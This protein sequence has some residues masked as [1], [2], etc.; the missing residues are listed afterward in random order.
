MK[1]FT[2]STGRC[3][4]LFASEVFRSLTGVPSFHEPYPW[5]VDKTLEEVNGVE[6]YS[7]E[8]GLELAAKI[9]QIRECSYGDWYFESNQMFIKSYAYQVL[10][11][12]KEIGVLY[13]ERNPVD[14]VLSYTKKSRNYG[15]GW[16]LRSN[17]KANMLRIDC[18]LPFYDNIL[19]QWFEIKER[20]NW[21]KKYCAKTYELDFKNINDPEE[22]KRI[23][24]CFGVEYKKFDVLTKHLNRNRT[25]ETDA[26]A[27]KKMIKNKNQPLL[28]IEPSGVEFKG[29]EYILE[30][31]KIAAAKQAA[32]VN[33]C[34]M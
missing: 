20:Y 16:F 31:A 10:H 7:K 25:L 15:S 28:D 11:N 30:Q 1:I 8:T 17:W 13:I 21:L 4:T 12:F 6:P 14:I 19:W 22:W 18:K 5:C 23:F 29:K 3:G 27:R 24:K 26:W 9:E 2:A 32:E 34:R 33:R